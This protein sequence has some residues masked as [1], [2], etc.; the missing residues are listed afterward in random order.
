MNRTRLVSVNDAV[1]GILHAVRHEINIRIHFAAAFVVAGMAAFFG[2]SRLEFIILALVVG[3]VLVCE[4][5]NTAVEASVDMITDHYHP[6]AKI[7]K[8]ISA[9]AV[10]VSSLVAAICG[11]LIFFPHLS[12]PW[13]EGIRLVKRTPAS[14]IMVIL[15]LVVLAVV[16]AKTYFGRG[17]PLS[18]GMPSGHSAVSFAMFTAVAMSTDNFLV[19]FLTL[20]LALMVSQSRLVL[21]IHTMSEVTA[22]AVLGILATLLLFRVFAVE[23]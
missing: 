8:D 21:R 6:M 2:L 7:I 15:I 13:L 1:E 22:G 11:Y 17:T 16:G 18:G 20:V 4:L 9:G 5:I 3:Q 10:L 19:V 14:V 12:E 23:G